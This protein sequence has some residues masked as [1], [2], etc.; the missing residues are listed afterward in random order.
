MRFLFVDRIIELSPGTIA[1]GVK[2]VTHDDYYLCQDNEGAWCFIPSLI[3]EA[4]GQLAAWNVMMS[5]AFTVRPVAGIA[6]SA[7]LV[8]PV[9]VGETLVLDAHLDVLD[10]TAVQYHGEARVGNEVVFRLDGALGPLLPMTDFIDEAVVRRQFD[11][12]NRPLL[13]PNEYGLTLGARSSCVESHVHAPRMVFD[14]VTESQPGARLTAVKRITRAAS[15]FPDHFPNKPVLPMTVLLECF[16][17]LANEFIT[18]AG[19]TQAYACREM[20]RIK[21]SDFIFPGDVVVGMITLKHQAIHELVLTCRAEVLG[22]RVGVLD[23]V[24]ALKGQSE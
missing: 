11:E 9:Y 4:I 3:G 20:R 5:H 16:L 17:N 10:E 7:S 1:R 24:M 2:H 18:R 6:S 12:I 21:M 8:R 15:Y 23:L 14:Q 22:K 19:F 13:S